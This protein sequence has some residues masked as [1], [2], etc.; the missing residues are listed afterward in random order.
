MEL[1]SL[2]RDEQEL[3]HARQDAGADLGWHRLAVSA[4]K[5]IDPEGPLWSAVLASTGQPRDLR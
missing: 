4:R 1:S 2:A 5:K 3:E